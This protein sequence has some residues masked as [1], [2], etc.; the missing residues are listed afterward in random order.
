MKL[1]NQG[2][3]IDTLRYRKLKAMTNSSIDPNI[4]EPLQKQIRRGADELDLARWYP[5][6]HG[7]VPEF[8]IGT[9]WYSVL[10]LI[11][12][13]FMG[14]VAVF[15]IGWEI[16]PLPMIQNFI[17]RYPGHLTA[18]GAYNGFP[19]WL[20]WQ[21]VFNIFLLMFIMR[22][23]IQILADHPR[24]YLENNCTPGKEWFRFQKPVPMDRLWTAR[25][26]AVTIP[27][28]LGIPGIRHSIGLARWWHFSCDVLWLL[29][30][31]VF[32]ALLF[33]TGQWMRLIPTSLAV[34]PNALSDVIQY[35][36]F[37]L[38][39]EN[40][41]VRYN[42]LQQLAYFTTVFI[43]AP[44]A[45]FSG[46]MQSPAISNRAG[47]FGKIFNRQVARTIH[48]AV[49]IWFVQF[50]VIHVTMV[51]VTGFRRNLNHIMVGTDNTA[52]TGTIIA[53]GIIT[54]LFALWIGASPFTIRHARLVQRVGKALVGPILGGMEIWAPTTQYSEKDIAPYLW[55]NGKIPDSQEFNSL[56]EGNFAGYKLPVHGLVSNPTDFSYDE[57]KA[58]PKA[59]QITNHFCIQGWTGVAKWG[60]VKMATIIEKVQPLPDAKYVVFYSFGESHDGAMYWDSHS[61]ENMRQDLSILAYEL[62][63]QLLPILHGAPLR[64]R[65]ENELGFKLVKWIRAIEFVA[66]FKSIGSGQGGYAE[67][68]EFYT[69]RNPI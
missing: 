14:M 61:I 38:P 4:P 54:F 41:W 68:N 9:H 24:L 58:M 17:A 31:L 45:V 32:Y 20:R 48:F 64:L 60:G 37:H 11:P 52:F 22:S 43:A 15:A 50:T 39:A 34:F 40:G 21:H 59:E 67:D 44:L 13:A 3:R 30:G 7:I 63:G 55:P 28:W 29:N 46:I 35:A 5:A 10:W 16:Y 12:L 19:W 36:S 53:A 62:N 23:G 66:E 26:D 42:S 49:L 56:A 69:Y 47:W 27:A 25:D 1:A 2:L 57:L 65:C 18:P 51:F 6:R 8:R 33:S